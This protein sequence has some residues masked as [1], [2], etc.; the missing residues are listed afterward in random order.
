MKG[1]CLYQFLFSVALFE[2]LVFISPNTIYG[3]WPLQCFVAIAFALFL[4][5]LSFRIDAFF[6][7]K[8]CS[9]Y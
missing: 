7:L 5:D 9:K 1:F 2:S 8:N 3:A 4:R 6:I